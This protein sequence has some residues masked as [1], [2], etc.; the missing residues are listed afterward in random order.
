MARLLTRRDVLGGLGLATAASL[1]GAGCGGPREPGTGEALAQAGVAERVGNPRRGGRIR[2]ASLSSST[3][4]TLDP[5][6]GA[7]STDYVRHYMLYSGL[8]R[9]DSNLRAQPALAKEIVTDDR[10]TWQIRL[11]SGVHFHDGSPLTADDVA[12]SLLRH[13]LPA[14]AS[15]MKTV[16]EQI[17]SVQVLGAHDLQITLVSANAD[18]PEILAASHFL[19]IKDGTKEFTA[20]NGC[21]PYQAARVQTRR[22]HSRRSQRKLLA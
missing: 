1:L 9:Y 4:D 22:T 2:V 13:K 19:I 11:H 6:K 15:K 10:L 16:A 21:G 17:A 12:Y 8:T 14:T 3:A 20:G 5:A 7:L 18:L